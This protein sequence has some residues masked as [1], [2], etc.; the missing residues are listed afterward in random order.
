MLILS[1]DQSMAC[2]G[3]AW[4]DSDGNVTTGIVKTKQD[5]NDPHNLGRL[6][7]I[8][9]TFEALVRKGCPDLLVLERYFVSNTR[10]SMAVA[11]V[12]G[13]LKLLAATYSIRMVEY[14]TS[15]V[16]KNVVG[17]GRAEKEEVADYVLQAY[18]SLRD[19]PRTL[20][21]T[22]ALAMAMHAM[23]IEENATTQTVTPTIDNKKKGKRK[24]ISSQKSSASGKAGAKESSGQSVT[25]KETKDSAASTSNNFKEAST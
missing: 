24:A 7:Y 9:N 23:R 11:D 20:D 16:R 14:V 5:K 25:S 18:P 1:I 12:R 13:V 4:L 2:S 21:E 8:Y 6:L 19:K 17:N 10:G 22:D 3:Y 15:S